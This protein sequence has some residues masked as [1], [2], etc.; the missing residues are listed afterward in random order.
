MA[1]PYDTY[2]QEGPLS[3]ISFCAFLA[4]MLGQLLEYCLHNRGHSL[5]IQGCGLVFSLRKS[6]GRASVH[7]DVA[8]SH[9]CAR[10][11]SRSSASNLWCRSRC[12]LGAVPCRAASC[13]NE[14]P[15]G[16]RRPHHRLVG[17]RVGFRVCFSS[18]H[19]SGIQRGCGSPLDAARIHRGA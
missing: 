4:M 15:V 1:E 5:W 13:M 8:L 10:K 7:I 18:L 16:R 2:M 6:K 17:S 14:R 12:R 19:V 3:F 11:A 9:V